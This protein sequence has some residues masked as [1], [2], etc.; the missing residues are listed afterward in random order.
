MEL[1]SN[2]FEV[3]KGGRDL[4]LGAIMNGIVLGP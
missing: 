3:F 2:C 1:I 4:L